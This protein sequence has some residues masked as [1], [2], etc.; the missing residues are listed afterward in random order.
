MASTGANAGHHDTDN[1]RRASKRARR[2]NNNNGGQ[3]PS[4]P[5]WNQ[6]G[7]AVYHALARG[8]GAHLS[9]RN[10]QQLAAASPGFRTLARELAPAPKAR[11]DMDRLRGAAARGGSGFAGVWSA[12]GAVPFAGSKV[13]IRNLRTVGDAAIL[14]TLPETV[15][16]VKVVI[17]WDAATRTDVEH[18]LHHKRRWTNLRS[19]ADNLRHCPRVRVLKVVFR[20]VPGDWLSLKNLSDNDK[21]RLYL[22]SDMSELATP[23]VEHLHVT[24]ECLAGSP[25]TH[26]DTELLLTE[27]REHTRKLENLT[28]FVLESD[29]QILSLQNLSPFLQAHAGTLETISI[30]APCGWRDAF[31]NL[32]GQATAWVGAEFPNLTHLRLPLS[33]SYSDSDQANAPPDSMAMWRLLWLLRT[34][35]SPRF[36]KLQDLDVSLP[37]PPTRLWSGQARRHVPALAQLAAFPA[38]LRRLTLRVTANWK[39]AERPRCIYRPAP[40]A[41]AGGKTVVLHYIDS[42][43]WSRNARPRLLYT[44]TFDSSAPEGGVPLTYGGQEGAQALQRS[45]PPNECGLIRPAL[46]VAAAPEGNTDP[47]ALQKRKRRAAKE[48]PLASSGSPTPPWHAGCGAPSRRCASAAFPTRWH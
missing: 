48:E 43:P 2:N 25:N 22:K 6:P 8:L 31:V 40:A 28:H 38:P 29:K 4:Q 9:H 17:P 32:Q 36:P 37:E 41:L 20:L 14:R 1:A 30:L 10:R 21:L 26:R 7:G 34:L 39:G 27:A 18:L 15:T 46:A 5:P 42:E 47:R 44:V 16:D 12:S 24:A 13:T 33:Y 45:F 11:L 19:I 35:A 23:H 3:P